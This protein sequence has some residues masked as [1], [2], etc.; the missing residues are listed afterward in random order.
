M[1]HPVLS[2]SLSKRIE[3]LPTLIHLQWRI[4][5][6]VFALFWRICGWL[7]P[8][9]ASAFGRWLFELVGPRSR[10]SNYMER[11]LRLAFPDLDEASREALLREVWGNTGAVFAEY[12]H[13]QTICQ[14]EYETRITVKSNLDLAKFRTGERQAIFVAAHIANWEVS[15]APALVQGFPLSVVYAPIKNP[16][17]DRMLI[18]KRIGLGCRL[19]SRNQSLPELMRALNKGECLGL[20]ADHRDDAGVPIPFFKHDKLTTLVPARLALRF[21]CD[22]VP[23]RVERLENAHFRVTLHDP[24]RPD[25]NLTSQSD[26]AVRMMAEVNRLFEEWISERPQQWLCSKRAWAKQ[27]D[28]QAPLKQDT[29]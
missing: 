12:P 8:D 21:D 27:I 4:E 17:I 2:K 10:K 29:G 16:Y 3:G 19:L 14:R 20:V 7:P 22:L 25:P 13:L 26:Q 6:A 18:R 24:I 5:A 9:R 11:N 1:A 28:V 23:V 15:T